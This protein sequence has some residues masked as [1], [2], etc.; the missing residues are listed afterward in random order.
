MILDGGLEPIGRYL[1]EESGTQ[2]YTQDY[3]D[4]LLCLPQADLKALKAL[5]WR[6]HW[7]PTVERS[8]S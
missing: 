4:Q 2:D 5:G 7:T 6:L 1:L 8:Y 3:S